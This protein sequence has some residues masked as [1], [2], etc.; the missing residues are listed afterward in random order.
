M[1]QGIGLDSLSEVDLTRIDDPK[2]TF[3]LFVVPK[4]WEFMLDQ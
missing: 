1:L 3:D 2:Q 4:E